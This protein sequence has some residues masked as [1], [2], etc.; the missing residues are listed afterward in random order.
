MVTDCY[1]VCCSVK[2][3]ALPLK[4]KNKLPL[5]RQNEKI[6]WLQMWGKKK[7]KMH[8]KV[9]AKQQP[10]NPPTTEDLECL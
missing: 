1:F 3:R 8:N 10:N 5:P 6:G 7:N 4:S 2:N 9:N